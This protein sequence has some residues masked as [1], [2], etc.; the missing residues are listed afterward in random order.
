MIDEAGIKSE[1]KN[2]FECF[3]PGEL[4]RAAR[5]ELRRLLMQREKRGLRDGKAAGREE[6]ERN[7]ACLLHCAFLDEYTIEASTGWACEMD[8]EFEW[9]KD[10]VSHGCI[11]HRTPPR[12][13]DEL[14]RSREGEKGKE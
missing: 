5:R 12:L 8:G 11:C 1:A 10:G 13:A 2:F 7:A 9:I 4:S 6:A 3:L 14:R